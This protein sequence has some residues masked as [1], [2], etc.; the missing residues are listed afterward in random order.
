M[1][2]AIIFLRCCAAGRTESWKSLEKSGTTVPICR[3][4]EFSFSGRPDGSI[5]TF[6]IR[7]GNLPERHPRLRGPSFARDIKVWRP[8]DDY[9]LEI[10]ILKLTL[11]E[12]ISADRFDLPQPEGTDLVRVGEDTPGA[13]R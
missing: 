10:H 5:P 8:Q 4:P 7:T 12:P 1:Q 9:K 6:D 3:S 2:D 13:Q 11:D